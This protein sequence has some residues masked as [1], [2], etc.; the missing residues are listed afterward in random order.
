MGTLSPV[1]HYSVII[2]MDNATPYNHGTTLGVAIS[3]GE[4]SGS[5][6]QIISRSRKY[7]RPVIGA[8]AVHTQRTSAANA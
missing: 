3:F 2:V 4:W 8:R 5:F 1:R 7:N 6:D